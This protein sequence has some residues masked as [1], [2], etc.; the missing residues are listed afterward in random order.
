MRYKER[1][2]P[3]RHMPSTKRTSAHNCAADVS[4]AVFSAPGRRE[5]KSWQRKWFSILIHFSFP[6]SRNRLTLYLGKFLAFKTPQVMHRFTLALCNVIST[7]G[8]LRFLSL[9]T[10]DQ[11]RVVSRARCCCFHVA[12]E[13]HS[14]DPKYAFLKRRYLPL[15]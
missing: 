1:A 5:E 7:C 4:C 6:H 9:V 14:E 10:C 2:T 11:V 8:H 3:S 13:G 12:N 15:F